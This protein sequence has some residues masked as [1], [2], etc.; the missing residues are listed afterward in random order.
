MAS[1]P[2]NSSVGTRHRE[3]LAGAE[4]GL[5]DRVMRG[6]KDLGYSRCG[7]VREF[8]GDSG[9]VGLVSDDC[10]SETTAVDQP[11]DAV[12]G[13]PAGYAFVYRYDL[14]CDLEP[15]DVRRGVARRRVAAFALGDD[16]WGD[17]GKRRPHHNLVASW[18]R[19][20][21]FLD[22]DYLMAASAAEYDRPRG[23]PSAGA[24]RVTA[25]KVK[26]VVGHSVRIP[27]SQ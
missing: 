5:E 1:A 23:R 20:Q 15:R 8:R 21:A 6:D 22:V 4:L 2:A 18:C 27:A 10:S 7:F 24:E 11:E 9:N 25:F 13:T 19:V 14:A 12:A 3:Q 16:R 17:P 26:E